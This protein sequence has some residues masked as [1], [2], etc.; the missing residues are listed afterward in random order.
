MGGV[1]VVEGLGVFFEHGD[2]GARSFFIK[3]LIEQG[4]LELKLLLGVN[5]HTEA[6]A[7]PIQVSY[8]FII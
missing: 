6:L 5:L 3:I 4:L 8:F 1:G 2:T 7:N